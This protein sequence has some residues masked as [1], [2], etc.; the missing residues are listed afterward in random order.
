MGRGWGEVELP[1][2]GGGG[3]G[4]GEEGSRRGG[5]K[6]TNVGGGENSMSVRGKERGY[7]NKVMGEGS[8]R[9]GVYR[10]RRT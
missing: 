2:P 6:E 3:L 1:Q 4:A 7:P 10:E 8:V 5:G 9:K